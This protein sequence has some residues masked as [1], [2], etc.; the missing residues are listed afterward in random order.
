MKKHD[1]ESHLGNSVGTEEEEL[2]DLEGC[3]TR[4]RTKSDRTKYSVLL[5]GLAEGLCSLL[6]VMERK[7]WVPGGGDWEAPVAVERQEEH[8]KLGGVY[9]H[10]CKDA[11]VSPWETPLRSR[12][13]FWAQL[14]PLAFKKGKREQNG[15]GHGS[16]RAKGWRDRLAVGQGGKLL[17][18]PVEGERTELEGGC[19]AAA[20]LQGP[21]QR[22]G[23]RCPETRMAGGLCCQA[24]LALFLPCWVA[25]GAGKPAGPA[26]GAR[27]C[28][29]HTGISRAPK[30]PRRR[31]PAWL[32][33]P[34]SEE[35]GRPFGARPG[36]RRKRRSVPLRRALPGSVQRA[37]GSSLLALSTCSSAAAASPSRRR[38]GQPWE[39]TSPPAVAPIAR[40]QALHPAWKPGEFFSM[41]PVTSGSSAQ[42][43]FQA[44]PRYAQRHYLL[45]GVFLDHRSAPPQAHAGV[46][47]VLPEEYAVAEMCASQL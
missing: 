17:S 28:W 12:L 42:R 44:L 19:P 36:S 16:R 21:C 5:R 46:S 18:Q 43:P 10:G 20:R 24:S 9:S 45:T 27:I 31:F 3:S 38:A 32:P 13:T 14:W 34:C 47:H 35:P 4:N 7:F 29:G 37:A 15:C 40:S 25:H 26:L 39:L 30:L 8:C 6:E 23:C 22:R 2:N 11:L 1:D 41:R 33:C